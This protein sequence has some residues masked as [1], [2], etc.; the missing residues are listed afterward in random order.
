[1][2]ATDAFVGDV[3]WLYDEC[4]AFAE[5]FGTEYNLAANEVYAKTYLQNLVTQHFVK[6]AFNEGER[7]GFIA[8]LVLPHPFNPA[9]KILQELLWWVP[10]KHRQTGAG[11][12]L[13]DSF[14]Q[15]GKD[16]V[17]I[18]HMALEDVSPIGDEVLLKRGFRFKEK[19]FIMET[20]KW[21]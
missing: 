9:I 20:K 15:F 18:I 13:L 19:A 3:D 21:R 7:L 14:I 2:I 5:F 4:K 16:N 8:G 11:K 12:L 1:M 10:E 6:I 17:D